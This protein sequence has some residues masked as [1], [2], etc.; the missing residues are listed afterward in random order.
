MKT[1]P[2]YL[3]KA[4]QRVVFANDANQLMEILPGE[5]G[6]LQVVIVGGDE[7]LIEAIFDKPVKNGQHG[8]IRF[9]PKKIPKNNDILPLLKGTGEFY[10]IKGIKDMGNINSQQGVSRVMAQVSNFSG[11]GAG[12]I[13]SLKNVSIGVAAIVVIVGLL[14]W[15]KVI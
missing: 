12:E 13:F 6:T 5:T 2:K 4:K 7:V 1:Y 11:A 9:Q 14:K 10:V 8:M 15:Q 3:V